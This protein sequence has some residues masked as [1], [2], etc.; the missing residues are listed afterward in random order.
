MKQQISLNAAVSGAFHL[1]S[2]ARVL[3]PALQRHRANADSDI[4]AGALARLARVLGD[5]GSHLLH[6]EANMPATVR[7]A[8]AADPA[9]TRDAQLSEKRCLGRGDAQ[10]NNA[11]GSMGC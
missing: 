7:D 1:G 9:H 6:L 2:R 8:L 11:S 10:A 4:E 3:A 5:F